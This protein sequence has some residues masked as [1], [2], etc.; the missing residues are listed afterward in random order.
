MAAEQD[1]LQLLVAALTAALRRS[2][3]YDRASLQDALYGW[4]AS[5][6]SV[7]EVRAWL[8]ADIADPTVAL[9]FRELGI[10]PDEVHAA[11]VGEQVTIGRLPIGEAARLIL[12]PHAASDTDQW[13][14]A[15]RNGRLADVDKATR[16][17]ARHAWRQSQIRRLDGLLGDR[18]A[19]P[20][21]AA[22]LAEQPDR[23]LLSY[24]DLAVA[25]AAPLTMAVARQELDHL[26]GPPGPDGPAAS[27]PLWTLIFGALSIRELTPRL[28]GR[29]EAAIMAPPAYLTALLG[30]YP[31]AA[32]AQLLWT[33][34]VLA[35]ETFRQDCEITDPEH[36]LGTPDAWLPLSERLRY[37][38]LNRALP[39]IGAELERARLDAQHHRRDG[40]LPG[41]ADTTGDSAG[42]WP[43]TTTNHWQ[44]AD[45]LLDPD[46]MRPDQELAEQVGS[47]IW[48]HPAAQRAARQPSPMAADFSDRELAAWWAILP[49]RQRRWTANLADEIL[50]ARWNQAVERHLQD[51]TQDLIRNHGRNALAEAA[52]LLSEIDRRVTT[53]VRTVMADPPVYLTSA[54]GPRPAAGDDSGMWE[55]LATEIEQYRLL[56]GTT[57][58]AEALGATPT[59]TSSWQQSWR[60]ELAGN[61][62]DAYHA[63]MHYQHRVI[64][65]PQERNHLAV[66][67]TSMI[68][69][70]LGVRPNPAMVEVSAA[71]AIGELHHRVATALPLLAQQP[72][73]PSSELRAAQLRHA[74]LL[75]YRQDEQVALAAA[76]PGAPSCG[77]QW[78]AAPGSPEPPPPT[79]FVGTSRPSLT[80]TTV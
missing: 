42:T 4:A 70:W 27:A 21:L 45:S 3:W 71:L 79:P 33:R 78:A 60:R 19:P 68:D 18:D 48:Q 2:G 63:R 74:R 26:G 67:T 38:Q 53:R 62:A 34:A 8:A 29:V 22:W 44:D 1:D 55:C 15:L 30:P 57:T 14:V 41:P 23:T 35:I 52:T 24:R 9:A 75:A 40:R 61:L 32:A 10:G 16:L 31:D 47:W 80:S 73:N 66:L 13:R 59:P 36:A 72:E 25:W 37:R 46:A 58:P 51:A 43:Q 56:T 77:G 5:G 12:G 17:K 6:L 49:E 64:G 11:E 39:G 65:T 54:L 69:P 7:G 20:A 28:G 50:A 76:A